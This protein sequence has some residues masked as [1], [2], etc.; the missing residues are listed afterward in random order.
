[1]IIL[2]ERC[3]REDD[4]CEPLSQ[5]ASDDSPKTFICI[6]IN[7][8]LNREVERDYL[9]KCVKSMHGVDQ[10]DNCDERDLIDEMSVIAQL[11]SAVANRK[12]NE[13]ID[14]Q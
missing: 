10:R 8:P 2:P 12:Y 7:D 5:I 1:M 14:K 9:T 11:F 13:E 3:L 6:G 4:T